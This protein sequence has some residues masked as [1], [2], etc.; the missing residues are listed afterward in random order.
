M[1]VANPANPGF[2][3]TSDSVPGHSHNVTIFC[4]QLTSAGAVHYT[5]TTNAG[6]SHSFDLSAAQLTTVNTGGTVNITSSTAS[7]HTH[8]WFITKPGGVC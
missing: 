8:Q 5:S 3:S 1:C 7:G 6:H 4:T 2:D